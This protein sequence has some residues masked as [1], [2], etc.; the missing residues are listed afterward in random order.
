MSLDDVPPKEQLN[1]IKALM[2]EHTH[3]HVG[4]VYNL[5]SMKWWQQWKMYAKENDPGPHPGP[6]NNDPLFTLG[7][8]FLKNDLVYNVDYILASPD[9]WQLLSNWYGASFEQHIGR[10]CENIG[11]DPLTTDP[12]KIIPYVDIS[13]LTVQICDDK[14]TI[15]YR[16][17]IF[18]KK[19][20]ILIVKHLICKNFNFD[21]DQMSLS[22]ESQNLKRS[23]NNEQN[24]LEEEH[25]QSGDKII[26]KKEQQKVKGQVQKQV[27]SSEDVLKI[28]VNDLNSRIEIQNERY[29]KLEHDSAEMEKRYLEQISKLQTRLQ[30]LSGDTIENMSLSELD[31]LEKNLR[32][33]TLQLEQKKRIVVQTEQKRLEMERKQFL[34]LKKCCICLDREK[35]TVLVDCFHYCV[36]SICANALEICPLCK[37]KIQTKKRI[38]Y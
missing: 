4:E 9:V 16:E 6:I 19:M 36:C 23:L 15:I 25:V 17:K 21:P 8:N 18:G 34:E 30:I 38:Y 20:R 31:E 2:D 10:D 1:L 7:T 37:S 13:P 12:Q 3:L 32:S 33:T 11:T 5:I 26:L 14:N 22:L 35:D 28:A 29:A 27:Q 24:T